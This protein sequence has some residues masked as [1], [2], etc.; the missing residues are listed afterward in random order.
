M[1]VCQT[2]DCGGRMQCAS[3]DATLFEV[4][5]GKSSDQDFH[6]AGSGGSREP[7]LTASSATTR[8][9]HPWLLLLLVFLF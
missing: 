6:D 2:G 4:T 1:G 7:G 5:L 8:F 3:V 9:I